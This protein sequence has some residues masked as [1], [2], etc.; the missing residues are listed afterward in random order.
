[1]GP[2]RTGRLCYLTEKVNLLS[3]T[4]MVVWFFSTFKTI[5]FYTL[6]GYWWGQGFGSSVRWRWLLIWLESDTPIQFQITRPE[7]CHLSTT[8][9]LVINRVRI[10]LTSPT[11]LIP[12]T[13]RRTQARTRDKTQLKWS[14]NCGYMIKILNMGFH[15]S[16]TMMT[17]QWQIDLKKNS[18]PNVDSSYWIYSLRGIQGPLFMSL[19]CPNTL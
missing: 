19:R 11:R 17:V 10:R 13:N 16:M 7:S 18:N 5:Y 14:D 1:M 8:S 15:K 3:S 12:I 6:S 2:Y 9:P 4:N